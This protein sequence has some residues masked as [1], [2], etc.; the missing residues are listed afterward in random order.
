MPDFGHEWKEGET[1]AYSTRHLEKRLLKQLK[2]YAVQKD[3][4]V[5][6]ALNEALKIGLAQLM[7]GL[8]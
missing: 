7:G 5:E 3:V 6:W 8:R 2:E 1:T 4:S